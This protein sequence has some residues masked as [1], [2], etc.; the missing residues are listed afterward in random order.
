M[1]CSIFRHPRVQHPAQY[2]FE[3]IPPASPDH[4][5][6]IV[7]A[8]SHLEAQM[9]T[10]VIFGENMVCSIFCHARVQHPAQY[11]FEFIPPASPDHNGVIFIALSHVEAE[12]WTIVI[13]LSFK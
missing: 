9:W 12:M 1:V 4:N 11:T 7:I 6:V 5:G 10:I 13:F 2:T 3:F 8:L